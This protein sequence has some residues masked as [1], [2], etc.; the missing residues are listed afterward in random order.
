MI[1][2]EFYKV[3]EDGV[4]LVR[5]YSDAGYIVRQDDT[6]VLY[7]EVIQSIREPISR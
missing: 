6:G 3:R 1:I 7:D 4:R 5:T 2:T